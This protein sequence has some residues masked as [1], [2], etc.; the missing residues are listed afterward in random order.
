MLTGGDLIQM[1]QCPDQPMRDIGEEEE[2]EGGVGFY[3][4]EADGE[5]QDWKMV[6]QCRPATPVYRLKFSPDGLLFASVGK[7]RRMKVT[8]Y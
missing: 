3:I 2:G 6:W 8:V 1:W 4:D 5:I 7:V